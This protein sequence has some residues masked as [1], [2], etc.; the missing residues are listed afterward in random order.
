MNPIMYSSIRSFRATFIFTLLT[1]L[2][3]LPNA[4]SAQCEADAGSFS[5]QEICV[6][7]I[8]FLV[9]AIPAGDAVTPEGYNVLYVLT[10]GEDLVIQQVSE[11]PKFTIENPAGLYTVH[12]LVY[13]EDLDLN[14]ITI[15]ETTGGEV[16]ALLIQGG[17]DICASLDVA[18]VK[19]RFGACDDEEPVCAVEAATISTTDAT[20]ICAGDGVPDPIDVAVSGGAGTNSAWIITDD[21]NNILAL[22]AAPPFDLDG[23]GA[24]ICRIWYLTYED[25]LLG[26]EVDLN[27][28]DLE[29]C[30]ALS[31]FITVTRLSGDECAQECL[32]EAGSLR[33]LNRPCVRDRAVTLRAS[34]NQMPT[35]PE[36]YEV[37][38]VLTLAPAFTIEQ[39][40]DSPMFSINEAGTYY[41]HTLVYNPATLD[42]NS[43]ALGETT[44]SSLNA[45]LVQGGGVI[46]AALDL[47]GAWFL[48]KDCPNYC[49]ARAGTLEVN[50]VSCFEQG[51]ASVNAKSKTPPNIPQG[52]GI[53]YILTAGE[54]LV[55]EQIGNK[56]EFF[57][58]SVGI[59]RVHRL[60]YNPTTLNL[61]SILLG[62]TTAAEVNAL[63]DQG[64]G[65]ICAALDLEGAEFNVRYCFSACPA[66]AGELWTQ[67]YV[68]CLR[69]YDNFARLVALPIRNPFVPQGYKVKYLL[70]YGNNKI[71]EQ[72]N[73]NPVFDV[74][75]A[76]EFTIHTFVYDPRTFDIEDD[77]VLGFTKISEINSKLF[78]GGGAICGALDVRGI[79]FKVRD[80]DSGHL[81]GNASLYPNPTNGIVNVQLNDF[82]KTK[83][84]QLQ[85]VDVHGAILQTW[86]VEQGTQSTQL[87]LSK[88]APGMYFLQIESNGELIQQERIVRAK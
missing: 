86:K 78:Q 25:D 83:N 72:I 44:A 65:D 21:E 5:T 4:L 84:V 47:R 68:V 1:F 20:A 17:G 3:A 60:V 32:A 22:P 41:I 62:E 33:A 48:V 53:K 67:F 43:I 28:N 50:Y 12:T 54:D 66:Y 29:G 73:D 8:G 57:V 7:D 79:S 61:N 37:A 35:V 80:C 74:Y 52:Y 34:I 27:A 23:A 15:G 87:D 69:D 2:L 75:R 38:Y 36:G 10:S 88:F 59:Y 55:I 71:I 11:E 30:F 76:E 39:I 46:C 6:Q 45:S 70:S 85:V 40:G 77:L 42:I 81:I 49:T 51:I 64:G 31:N 56:P 82:A 26:L 19:F 58:D 16:N 13:N 63:L 9:K 14:A 18:G 24:G